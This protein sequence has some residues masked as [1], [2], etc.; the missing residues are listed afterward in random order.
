MRQPHETSLNRGATS[1]VRNLVVESTLVMQRVYHAEQE[2]PQNMG[3]QAQALISGPCR[4]QPG[5][6]LLAG[7]LRPAP[8]RALR[9]SG[10]ADTPYC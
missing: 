4:R 7:L 2:I 9:L 8:A 3:T 6:L 5:S 10:L 1:Q